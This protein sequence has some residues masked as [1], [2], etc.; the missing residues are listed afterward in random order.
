VRRIV[1]GTVLGV[2]ASV[3]LHA[4]RARRLRPQRSQVREASREFTAEAAGEAELA[5]LTREELYER[6]R[7]Q[8]IRG[9]SEMT[10]EQLIDALRG[11][12]RDG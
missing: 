12:R 4:A 7:A 9:R 5:T 10:K 8:K 11:R 6:A 1:L 2:V 3:A